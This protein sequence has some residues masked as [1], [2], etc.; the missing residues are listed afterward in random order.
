M[1]RKSLIS[2]VIVLLAAT[3]LGMPTTTNAAPPPVPVQVLG[4]TDLHGYLSEA[5]NQTIAGPAGSA[6][7][8]AAYLKA[9]LDR[10][11]AGQPNSFLIG[12][13]DQF[14]GWPDYTQAFANE[15]T[16]EVLNAL[17]M[18]FD[19]A[20]NH[21]FDR[22]F[23]FLQRMVSGDCYGTPGFDSCFPDS[24]GKPFAGTGYAY[25]AANMLTAKTKR[26]VLPPY[27]I[28]QAGE[29]RGSASSG[30]DSRARRR[31]RCRSAQRLRVPGPG[32]APTGRRPNCR[33][34][35]SKR[36]SSACTKAVSSRGCTTSAR[37]RPARC[38]TRRR[39]CRR[40]S[41]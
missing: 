22:E 30:S 40:R 28:A 41:T 7:G 37:T 34:R 11:R 23:P 27:W 21:E 2:A 25:H 32:E 35:A 16:I 5:E 31:R 36:S 38:S 4:I 33:P 13:G 1:R 8:G 26:P 15:P 10:L 39:R 14:S 17:G 3:L 6:V 19:V 20:G 24:T 12:S 18:D 9:H 29:R